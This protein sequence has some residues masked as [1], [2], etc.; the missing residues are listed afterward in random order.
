[1][2]NIRDFYTPVKLRRQKFTATA[3]QT[4]FNLTTVT[5]PNSDSERLLMMIDGQQQPSDAYTINS[6]TQVTISE[7]MEGGEEVE[8]IVPGLG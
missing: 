7:S 4:I 6:P 8:F 5:I 1:M 3:S 2:S